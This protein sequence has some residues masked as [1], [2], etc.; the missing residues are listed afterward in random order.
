MSGKNVKQS[1]QQTALLSTKLDRGVKESSPYFDGNK[2]T[3]VN[4]MSNRGQ[5]EKREDKFPLK[6]EIIANNPQH[7]LLTWSTGLEQACYCSLTLVHRTGWNSANVQFIPRFD[8]LHCE[9]WMYSNSKVIRMR[10][11]L[12][13]RFAWWKSWGRPWWACE[14][15]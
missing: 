10:Q 1:Q 5:Y 2:E 11:P 14:P 9:K 8:V 3:L 12:D 4:N 6:L 15:C 13:P 7:P